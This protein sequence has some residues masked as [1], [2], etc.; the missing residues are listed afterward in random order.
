MSLQ[1]HGFGAPRL[2]D[3]LP[4]VEASEANQR[5]EKRWRAPG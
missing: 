5:E 2:Y 1:K 4:S 3:M